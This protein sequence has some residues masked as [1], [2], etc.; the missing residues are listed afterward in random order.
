MTYILPRCDEKT[1]GDEHNHCGLVQFQSGLYFVND[2]DGGD[3]I[4]RIRPFV[5]L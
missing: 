4:R 1:A 5:L 3:G 2:D